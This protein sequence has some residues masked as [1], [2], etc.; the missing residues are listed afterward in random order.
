MFT[1]GALKDG[2]TG[3]LSG[4]NL[5]TVTGLNKALERA[6][7]K[8]A[9]K[10][11][12]PEASGIQQITLYDGVFDY[13][14]DTN[15]FGNSIVD[16]APQGVTRSY[17]D[18]VVKQPKAYFDR[19]KLYCP[20]G[21]QVTFKHN[22]GVP[23]VRIATPKPLPRVT[24][25]SMKETT[26]WTAAGSTSALT[27]D[28]TVFYESPSS[29]KFTLTGSS[30]GTLTKTITEVDISSYEDV[31]VAFLAIR[32]PDGATATNLTSIALRLGSSASVYDE[33]SDTEGFLGAWTAGEW[34]LVAFDFSGA[35]STGTPDWEKIDYAQVRLAH[36]GTLTNFR[37]G[38]L[39][40]A[41]PSPHEFLYQ[42]AA[43]FLNDGTLN[44]T[45]TDD[46]DEII[47]NDAAYILYE[48]ECAL[49][50]ALQKT[51]SKKASELR[52]ILYGG[53]DR[54]GLYDQ[55]R[56]NNPSEQL[57]Q[58]GSYYDAY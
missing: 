33:V 36:S 37:V 25:D 35:T 28:K 49:G 39:W 15:I 56:A 41:L 45:I 43:I 4:T 48:H 27:Q 55:Y 30:T 9:Q 32:I 8:L 19:T 47:L 1:V 42:T 21:Y 44:K 40:I 7:R 58:V 10:A 17:L 16:L 29:L 24:L 38:G 22:K 57:R 6:A 11:D 53:E 12:V 50:I 20:S 2:V 46:D 5:D 23:M 34:L 13:L 26:D 54:M 3:L 52:A 51:M 31:G 18:D 14:A